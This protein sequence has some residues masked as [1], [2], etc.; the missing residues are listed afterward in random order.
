MKVATVS[1][2]GERRVGRVTDDGRSLAPFDLP[3]AE[4]QDG[5]LRS[6][7]PRRTQ[8]LRHSDHHRD[9]VRRH[10]PAAGDVIATGTPPASA[11][12]TIRRNISRPAT[13][14]ASRSAESAFLR[15][16]SW[17]DPHDFRSRARHDGRL[18]RRRAAGHDAAWA[19]RHLQQFSADHA[20]AGRLSRHASRFAGRRPLADAARKRSL[21]DCWWKQSSMPPRISASAA[22]MSS[23][24]PSA[25]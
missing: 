3:L 14:C 10:H 25:L 20:R 18:R 22:R 9:L 23:A 5:V 4:A 24:I 12:A 7:P 17:S 11:S 21:S 16:K 2:A 15:T 13:S 8:P 6:G 19:R 1:I